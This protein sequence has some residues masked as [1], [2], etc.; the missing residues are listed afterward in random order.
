MIVLLPVASAEPR[1]RSSSVQ[2][3]VEPAHM[4][5]VEFA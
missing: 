3:I 2:M 1:Q 5:I 4:S